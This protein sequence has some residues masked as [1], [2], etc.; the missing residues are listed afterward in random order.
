MGFLLFK[1]IS[2]G[3]IV[4]GTVDDK[5]A[6]TLFIRVDSVYYGPNRWINDLKIKVLLLQFQANESQVHTFVNFSF[7][8]TL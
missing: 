5:W 3:D 4:E 7:F 2:I 8:A 1:A 6:D